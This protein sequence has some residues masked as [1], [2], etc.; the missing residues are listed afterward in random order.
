MPRSLTMTGA[1]TML[2]SATC[3]RIRPASAALISARVFIAAVEPS[4]EDLDLL[5]RLFGELADEGAEHFGELDER[6]QAR[7]FLGRD[8]RHVEGVGDRALDQVVRHL[9][10]DLQRDI[11]LR[12]RGRGAEMRR[13]DDVRQ[14]EQRVVR[15]RLDLEHVERRRR[16]PCRTSSAVDQSASST[17][18]PRAQLMM[19]TP[20]FI[21]A[22]ASA[23]MMLR[24]LSVSGVCSVMKSARAN[25]SSSSTFS[26]PSSSARA[27]DR[28]GSK[29]TTCIFRPTARVAT[30]EPILP[31][32]MTPSVL[33]VISTP[34]KRFFSHLPAWV[35]ALAAGIC[36]RQ[37]EHQR[38]RVLGRGD[39]IAE[40][41]VHHDD[42]ARGGGRD[43]DI[44]DADAGAADD[45]E[46]GRGGDQLFGDLGGRADGEAVI[47]ADDFEQLVLVLAEI[48]LVVDLDAAI[49]EDLDGGVGKLVG[50]ENAWCH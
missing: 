2:T 43:V 25:S 49:L 40:G 17:S 7:R 38:D 41:R 12:F 31:Q 16:R 15:R 50:Y 33:P 4:I 5:D 29:A 23:S 10:G 18:P 28:N 36:A 6:L 9:L 20:F 11:L 13:A 3:G 37:R 21:L 26:T 48:R 35:E 39:R 30:I 45:L 24:V 19:R 47:L 1:E 46:L 22:I 42:A 34:M 8:R 32:P 14:A 27:P 44:V